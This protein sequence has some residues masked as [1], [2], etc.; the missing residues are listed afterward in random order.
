[1]SSDAVLSLSEDRYG[2]LWVATAAGLSRWDRRTGRFT[3]Y[4][5]H[6]EDPY[7]LSDD[8]VKTVFE[9]RDGVLWVDPGRTKPL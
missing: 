5:H 2:T 6:P 9:D 7:S 8:F 1:L 3:V 4:R